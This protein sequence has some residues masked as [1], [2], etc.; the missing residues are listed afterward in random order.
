MDS[1]SEPRKT[2]VIRAP[3]AV[4]MLRSERT[5]LLKPR[6][7]ARELDQVSCT[8]DVIEE[9]CR[10]G[11]PVHLLGRGAAIA[12]VDGV[13]A[14]PARFAVLDQQVAQCVAEIDFVGDAT[15]HVL[16]FRPTDHLAAAGVDVLQPV[17]AHDAH[18]RA[19]VASDSFELWPASLG[20]RERPGLR[21]PGRTA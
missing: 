5:R 19:G 8:I 20:A 14:A 17:A 15:D 18:A 10:H 3:A 13:V 16:P 6:G 12:D 7:P 11:G 21:A 9:P 4:C 1:D 2:I